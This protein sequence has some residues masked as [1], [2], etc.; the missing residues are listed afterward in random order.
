VVEDFHIESLHNP[1]KPIAFYYWKPTMC[2]LL[3]RLHPD[4]INE[5][6][7]KIEE[8]WDRTGPPTVFNYRFYDDILEAEYSSEQKMASL[9]NYF[10]ILAI[11]ITCLGLLAISIFNSERRTKEIGMR[12]SI[13]ASV[14]NISMLLMKEYIILVI[15]STIISM[16]VTYYLMQRWLGNFAYKVNIEF[17]VFLL[18]GF[19]CLLITLLTVSIQT[20][21]AAR[22]NP[23]DVLRYE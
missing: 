7:L 12:K 10:S 9:L 8:I 2:Y 16:P 5:T 14:R 15:L 23:V 1:I 4:N 18:A 20:I 19:V 17:W 11:F 3:L 22:K 13:G 21:R 6:L